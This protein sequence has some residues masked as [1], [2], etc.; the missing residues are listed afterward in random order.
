M[1]FDG[2]AA[3]RIVLTGLRATGHLGVFEHERQDGQEFV[4]DVT[5]HL[6]LHDAAAGVKADLIV[7]G[8]QEDTLRLSLTRRA[9]DKPRDAR[10]HRER[11]ISDGAVPGV[12]LATFSSGTL[13]T[14]DEGTV[15]SPMAWAV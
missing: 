7:G 5:V 12:N 1:S 11:L 3:D 9:H 8:S 15:S 14:L 13:P 6:S 10:N 4:I 2:T